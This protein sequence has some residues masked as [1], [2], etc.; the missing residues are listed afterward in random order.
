MLLFNQNHEQLNVGDIKAE[1]ENVD[2]T[3][4][5]STKELENELGDYYNQA[6][7]LE[8][9]KYQ[10]T[11]KFANAATDNF[12]VSES[13]FPKIGQD[14][15]EAIKKFVCGKVDGSSTSSEIIDVILD[16]IVSII[17]GGI[18]LKPIVKKLVKYILSI[19][20]SNFCST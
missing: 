17:P 16:A 19:G 20:I 6:L 14:I 4:V 18:L 5:L 9:N 12:L 8:G 13:F 2:H 15:L 1:L 10:F 7:K 3:E 11:T